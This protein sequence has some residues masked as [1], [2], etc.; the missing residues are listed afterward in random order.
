MKRILSIAI[1]VGWLSLS[2]TMALAS[3]RIIVATFSDSNKAYDAAKAVKDL[4]DAGGID[5]KLKTGVIIAK[6]QTETCRCWKAEV[7]LSWRGRG[8]RHRR[9][10]WADRR[11]ARCGGGGFLGAT[12]GLGADVVTGMLDSG[13]INSVRVSIVP[14]TTAIILEANKAT[15]VRSMTSWLATAVTSIVRPHGETSCSRCQG[16]VAVPASRRERE[17]R[18]KATRSMIVGWTATATR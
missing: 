3:D 8:N 2:A 17:T 10:D 13:L 7:V 1:A 15:P 16:D 9:P 5:F 6:D 11:C 12:T 18:A 14:G 4:K